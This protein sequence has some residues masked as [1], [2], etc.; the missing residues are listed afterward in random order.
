MLRGDAAT[1]AGLAAEVETQPRGA[2]HD[3][4][5]GSIA[6]AADDPSVAE[7][8]L[9]AAWKAG[10]AAGE[11]EL[12]GIVALMTG[13]HWYGRLDAGATVRWCTEALAQFPPGTSTHAVAQTYLIHGLGYAGRTAEAAVVA[14]AADEHG[15]QQGDSVAQSPLSPRRHATDG[16]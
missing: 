11:A 9:T 3:L 7:R 2:L 14:G 8:L 12:A 6:M 10:R 13:M 15:G 5:L 1:A 4:A 16:R